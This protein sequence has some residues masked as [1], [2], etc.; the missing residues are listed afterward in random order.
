MA[1]LT[2]HGYVGKSQLLKVKFFEKA[3]TERR[4]GLLLPGHNPV[5][6]HSTSSPCRP[7]V[8]VG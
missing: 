2:V 7:W 1:W 8:I 4:L 5:I 6:D 3:K